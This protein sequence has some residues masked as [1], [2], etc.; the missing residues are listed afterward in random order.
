LFD[1]ETG[2]SITEPV[3]CAVWAGELC[4]SSIV[5]IEAS[6]GFKR[7]GRQIM[8]N[9]QVSR[10]NQFLQPSIDTQNYGSNGMHQALV[11][12]GGE[13]V[14]GAITTAMGGPWDALGAQLVL[15]AGGSALGLRVNDSRGL[16]TEDPLNPDAYDMLIVA[17]NPDSLTFL[18]DAVNQAWA[19]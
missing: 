14:T 8:D 19:A 13:Y 7:D 10:L 1:V 3:K 9:E 12:N 17:N 5:F 15:E 4:A 18:H 16:E 11:A 6:R 2:K